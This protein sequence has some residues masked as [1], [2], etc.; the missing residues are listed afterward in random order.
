MEI[1]K[2]ENPRECYHDGKV[3]CYNCGLPFP[4]IKFSPNSPF[5]LETED[6]GLRTISF[7]QWDVA[8]APK[9]YQTVHVNPEA[10]D[11]LSEYTLSFFGG[12]EAN[13]HLRFAPFPGTAIHLRGSTLIVPYAIG[14]VRVR[15]KRGPA[16]ASDDPPGLTDS[17]M[18]LAT[19]KEET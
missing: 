4:S 14:D 7:L 8:L 9:E 16:L 13:A 2:C 11:F 1:C 5:R 18:N 12:G 10:V 15:L 6:H 17:Q 19:W 3:V